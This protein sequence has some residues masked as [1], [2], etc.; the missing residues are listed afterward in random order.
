[1]NN[2]SLKVAVQGQYY[3]CRPLI[4]S[5]I[6]NDNPRVPH[7]ATSRRWSPTTGPRP[8]GRGKSFQTGLLCQW[9]ENFYV[10]TDKIDVR[11][12]LQKT[13]ERKKLRGFSPQAN[14]TDRPT[15][16]CRRS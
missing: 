8:T 10:T 16:A 5:F 15:A 9:P 6:I 7:V 4:H 13:K 11:A 3:Y 12:G 14:Y 2:R 1:M